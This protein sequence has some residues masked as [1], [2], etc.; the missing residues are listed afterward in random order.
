MLVTQSVYVL[1]PTVVYRTRTNFV[2][3]VNRVRGS[4]CN[5]AVPIYR[6]CHPIFP[7]PK[8][9]LTP[10]LL[11]AKPI[12]PYRPASQQCQEICIMWHFG[13]C[14]KFTGFFAISPLLFLC[15]KHLQRFHLGR[16][17]SIMRNQ[18]V[19]PATSPLI[20][21]ATAPSG[22]AESVIT[23][24]TCNLGRDTEYPD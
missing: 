9:S 1:R 8:D 20:T 22:L 6:Y 17:I 24:L 5:V 21:G 12:R 4:T 10:P 15:T 7:S 16:P 19:F 18:Q 13:C 3:K 2:S 14:Q 11:H 23:L